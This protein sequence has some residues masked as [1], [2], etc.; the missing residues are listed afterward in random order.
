[1]SESQQI[2]PFTG[3]TVEDDLV[4][5]RSWQL[6]TDEFL[7]YFFVAFLPEPESKGALAANLPDAMGF[8]TRDGGTE[9]FRADSDGDFSGF[10]LVLSG[11]GF[12]VDGDGNPTAGTA[13]GFEVFKDGEK[14]SSFEFLQSFAITDLLDAIEVEAGDRYTPTAYSAFAQL[15]VPSFGFLIGTGSD[16]SDTFYSAQGDD[17]I[18]ANAGNDVF[19]MTEGDDEVDGDLGR[20]MVDARYAASGITIDAAA[21]TAAYGSFNATLTGFEDVIG[22]EFDDTIKGSGA[23]NWLFGHDGDDMLFG[24]GGKDIFAFIADNSTD[25]IKDFKDGTD[26]LDLRLFDFASKAQALFA[27]EEVGNKRD[28]R[29]EFSFEGTTV[30]II[31]ADRF[32][33]SGADIIV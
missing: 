25:Q 10:E 21:G 26:K 28:N 1:M 18:D 27:F 33:I 3:M 17:Q 4:N 8:S 23:K 13:T 16:G 14:V 9:L 20:D 19:F 31:G 32:D 30:Q 5:S 11:S 15:L 24:R 12:S 22:S 6:S 7:F 29:S 2:Q